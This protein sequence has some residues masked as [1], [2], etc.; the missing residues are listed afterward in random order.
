MPNVIF[1]AGPNGAGKTTFASEYLSAEERGYEF[2]NADEIARRLAAAAV[3]H[4]QTEVQAA[5]MMLGRVEALVST[6]AD[7]VVETTLASLTYARKIPDWRKLGYQ[8]TLIYLRLP[9]VDA[10]LARVRKRVA[11]GGH[12][13][14]EEAVKRRFE[15]S[16]IYLDTIYKPLVDVWYLY[17]SREG[18][19]A[20]LDSWKRS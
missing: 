6:N 3:V 7:F 15:K 9:S 18:G 4:A 14:P 16:L 19:F 5:R 2:V 1:I 11:A 20:L 13:I 10:S 17:E 8:V 12:N